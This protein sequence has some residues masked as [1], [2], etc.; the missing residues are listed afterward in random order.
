MIPKGPLIK[1]YSLTGL[2]YKVKYELQREWVNFSSS[3]T[4]IIMEGG[5]NND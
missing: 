1:Y 4:N 2:G 5:V 3:V